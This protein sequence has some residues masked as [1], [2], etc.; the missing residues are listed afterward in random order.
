MLWVFKDNEF[1]DEFVGA[2]LP[3]PLN[4]ID[5]IHAL[6]SHMSA[7]RQHRTFLNDGNDLFNKYIINMLGKDLGDKFKLEEDE[8]LLYNSVPYE[9]IRFKASLVVSFSEVLKRSC[10]GNENNV[11][12]SVEHKKLLTQLLEHPIFKDDIKRVNKLSGAHI[13]GYRTF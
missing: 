12:F 9:Y 11:E 6:T 10:V 7:Q 1:T 4:S 5:L 13:F 8:K 3:L 2:P